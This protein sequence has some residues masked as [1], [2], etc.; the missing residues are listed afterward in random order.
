LLRGTTLAVAPSLAH[1]EMKNKVI[2][3]KFNAWFEGELKNGLTDIKISVNHKLG[4]SAI[5]LKKELL[6]C[7]A[8]VK[9]GKTKPFPVPTTFLPPELEA[10]INS[11]RL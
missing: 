7:E 6:N 9:S 3:D 1:K 2:D 5:A 11:V 10:I 4:I 8:L